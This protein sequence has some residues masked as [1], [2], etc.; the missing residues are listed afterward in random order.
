M[1]EAYEYASNACY[2][3]HKNNPHLFPNEGTPDFAF[4]LDG[5][6]KVGMTYLATH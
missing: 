4:N 5:G 3:W 2:E 6:Y 1:C